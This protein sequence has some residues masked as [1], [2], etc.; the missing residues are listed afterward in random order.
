[1]SGK[2]DSNSRLQPWQGC[3]LP[4][5]YSRRKCQRSE[6]MEA[7]PGFEPGMEVLQTSALASWLCRLKSGKR[8]SNSRLQPWQGCTLPLSYS[9]VLHR[10]SVDTIYPP[11]LP[12]STTF[13]RFPRT[14]WICCASL[15]LRPFKHHPR[16]LSCQRR[17]N[18]RMC[19]IASFSKRSKSR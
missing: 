17:S 10:R 2:R 4:L 5:S 12:L 3:T 13:F 1:M 18:S 14:S 9:R 6:E 19:C 11:P 7:T 8:D 15:G 16:F